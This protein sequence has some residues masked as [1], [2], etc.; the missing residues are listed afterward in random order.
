MRDLA[1][2]GGLSDLLL[3]LNSG[4]LWWVGCHGS[5]RKGTQPQRPGPQPSPSSPF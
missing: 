1:E 3:H 4:G 5:Y 2:L